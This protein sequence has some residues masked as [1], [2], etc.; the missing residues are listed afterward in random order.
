MRITWALVLYHLSQLNLFIYFKSKNEHSKEVIGQED[1][2]I[3]IK[4]ET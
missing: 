3:F 1:G 4:E 2:L